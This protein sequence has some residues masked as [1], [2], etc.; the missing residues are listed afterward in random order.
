MKECKALFRFYEELNDFLPPQQ[1]KRDIELGF[2][3]PAPVRHLIETLGVPHTE[4]ELILLNGRSVGLDQ[5]V[6]DGDRVSVYPMFESLD[7]RPLLRLRAQPLRNPR[8]VADAH[9]GKLARL[10]RMLGFDTLFSNDTGDSRMAELAADEG[11]VLLTR[12]RALLMRRIL[13]HGCYIRASEPRAQLLQVMNRLDLFAALQPFS[14]CMECNQPLA[15]TEKTALE[16]ELPKGVLEHYNEFWQCTG[17][18]RVYWKGHHYWAMQAWI[19][20]MQE[21]RRR[22]AASDS[23]TNQEQPK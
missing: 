21:E 8:F 19:A 4:V 23:A 5:A 22:L 1:R 3:P 16:A 7:L 14:R 6:Q 2:K 20:A 18:G 13:T 10:L 9:L 17:C 15:V 12:D 11:R